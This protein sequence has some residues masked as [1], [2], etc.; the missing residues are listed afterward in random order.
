MVRAAARDVGA[1]GASL[2]GAVRVRARLAR[3]R[4]VRAAGGGDGRRALRGLPERRR[5]RAGRSGGERLGWARPPPRL[6]GPPRPAPG[7]RL[8]RRLRPPPARRPR[9]RA[10]AGPG[11]ALAAPRRLHRPR[12][13]RRAPAAAAGLDAAGHAVVRCR[14]LGGERQRAGYGGRAG[15]AVAR[16]PPFRRGRAH[17]L[18]PA[19]LFLGPDLCCREHDQCS[20]QITALQFNYG[21]RNYRLHTVSHCDCD[22]RCAGPE[23]GAPGGG[24]RVPGGR[25]ASHRPRL[26]RRFRQCLLALNDTIS[27]IIGVTFFNLLEVP[28][29]VLEESEECVQWHWWG[30]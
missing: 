16:S 14:R 19:G 26:P 12:S 29:F 28:C 25:R 4:R 27:N 5:P 2:R 9:R 13:A 6:L 11:R 24:E 17:R 1:R 23:G 20:A 8:P 21:I 30:G 10:A 7:P 22:A 18:L 3:R 15:A